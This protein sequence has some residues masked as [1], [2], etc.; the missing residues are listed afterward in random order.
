MLPTPQATADTSNES[1]KLPTV[2][3]IA[4]GTLIKINGLPY[5]VVDPTKI[6][7]FHEPTDPPPFIP[8]CFSSDNSIPPADKP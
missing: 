7:G 8:G 1:P 6:S 5:T 2:W 3:T 4:P